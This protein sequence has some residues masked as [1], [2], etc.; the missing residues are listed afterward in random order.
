MGLLL[1]G[2]PKF[3]GWDCIDK[4]PKSDKSP[5]RSQLLLEATGC[6]GDPLINE[7]SPSGE[8][9]VGSETPLN[10]LGTVD[11]I[12]GGGI[13]FGKTFG[14]PPI[15]WELFWLSEK[16]VVKSAKPSLDL[17]VCAWPPNAVSK[18]PNSLT[19]FGLLLSPALGSKSSFNKLL[20]TNY[21]SY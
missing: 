7:G 5:R 15:N 18:S 3:C 14:K 20:A 13:T 21:H 10:R 4:F 11:D 6:A 12:F 2:K 8:I 17:S 19:I 9:F 1:D 16:A